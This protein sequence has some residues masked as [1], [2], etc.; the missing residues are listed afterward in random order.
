MDDLPRKNRSL[1]TQAAAGH[2]SQG[3][4]APS[5]VSRMPLDPAGAALLQVRARE[6]LTEQLTH[7][8]DVWTVSGNSDS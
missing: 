1:H 3:S 6:A 7:E 2:S 8:G 4:S 5:S